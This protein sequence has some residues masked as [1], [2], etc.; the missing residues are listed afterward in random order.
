MRAYERI[1]R[2][3]ISLAVESSHPR[4]KKAD[5]NSKID[6]K[7]LYIIVPFQKVNIC[8]CPLSPEALVRVREGTAWEG[9]GG[10]T[11]PAAE[12]ETS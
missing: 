10:A 12:G 8:G 2:Q 7:I 6:T 4:T 9:G 5:D 1:S 3:I 11:A